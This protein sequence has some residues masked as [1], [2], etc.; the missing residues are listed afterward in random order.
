[1]SGYT[2]L[3]G[4]LTKG[5]L[6]GKWPDIG[7]WPVLLSMADWRG[8][9]DATQ[10]YIATVTGLSL[11]DVTDCM[12]RF[13]EPDPRS[14]SQEAQGARLVLVDPNRD[15]GWKVVNI[16]K[17]RDKASDMAQVSDGRNAEK[18]KRYKERKKTPPDTAGHPQTLTHTHTDTHTKS[19]EE[20]FRL[21][22][23]TSG[24]EPERTPKLQAAIDKIGGWTKIRDLKQYDLPDAIAA[25]CEAYQ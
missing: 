4:S 8:E 13:C 12:K 20:I 23:K 2:P 15:W 16:Q 1:M 3:F 25:F 6:C 19:S 11:E 10:Q 22:L 21:L 5:T 24:K 17:Y 7:L 14:R 9:I 18:V